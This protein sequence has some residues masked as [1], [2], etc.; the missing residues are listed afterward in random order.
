MA[1]IEK[2]ILERVTPPRLPIIQYSIDASS[3]SGSAVSFRN[4]RI[5]CA[6]ACTAIPARTIEEGLFP[7]ARAES[8]RETHTARSPPTKA[9]T[10]VPTMP[11]ETKRIAKAAPAL[12]PEETPMMSGEAR[13][14]PKMV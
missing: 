3:F 7:G 11:E 8:P 4:I 13:G 14:F 12:A 10:V 6:S 9:K 5:V 2:G 1:A